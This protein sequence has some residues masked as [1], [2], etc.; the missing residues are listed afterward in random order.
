MPVWQTNSYYWNFFRWKIFFCVETVETGNIYHFSEKKQTHFHIEV[1]HKFS[2]D[3][4]RTE[5]QNKT[6]LI[7]SKFE[8]F[9]TFSSAKNHEKTLK[10]IEKA[11]SVFLQSCLLKF[12][13]LIEKFVDFYQKK[14]TKFL[15]MKILIR[16]IL[17]K[18]L[19]IVFHF[20]SYYL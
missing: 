7:G 1:L 2:R 15:K 8:F 14:S 5:Y 10:T 19:D 11:Y 20:S 16:K 4:F 6:V 3:Y 18:F 9:Q 17:S 12:V 13:T